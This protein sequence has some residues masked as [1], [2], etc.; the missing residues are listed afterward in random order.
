ME[1]RPRLCRRE[2]EGC[3]NERRPVRLDGRLCALPRFNRLRLD[4]QPRPSGS[5]SWARRLQ[6]HPALAHHL[7][8][9]AHRAE[10]P[11]TTSWY[12]VKKGAK[13]NWQGGHKA[14]TL[15]E[16]DNPRKSETGHSAQKPV[17]CM[18]RAIHNRLGDVY[19]PFV[20]SGTTVIAGEQ[21]GR[22]VYALEI[23]PAYVDVTVKRW[24]DFTGRKATKTKGE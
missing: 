2:S 20:G 8:Q 12:A 14:S 11:V 5:H 23:A 3:I 19:D 7:G 22:R 18:Q 6:L 16:I 4:E 13:A 9:G 15:W 1:R 10:P 24:E 21:E 17:E